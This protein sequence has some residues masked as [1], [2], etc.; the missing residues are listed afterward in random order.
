[1]RI[2]LGTV[3]LTDEE[4]KAIAAFYYTKGLANRE[5]CRRYMLDVA[6]AEIDSLVWYYKEDS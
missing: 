5:F 2:A 3:D 1:M 6:K 4:R